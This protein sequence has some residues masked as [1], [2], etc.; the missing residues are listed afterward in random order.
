MCKQTRNSHDDV[1][2]RI[3]K[4][5]S[6]T[7]S[8]ANHIN[9]KMMHMHVAAQ[10]LQRFEERVITVKIPGPVSSARVGKRN[11]PDFATTLL[12][13]GRHATRAHAVAQA[14]KKN[15]RP[16]QCTALTSMNSTGLCEST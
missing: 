8:C 3:A 2:I 6:S 13:G 16:G 4:H 15:K 10:Q 11:P 12:C 1:N 9:A 14:Q 5:C 7:C